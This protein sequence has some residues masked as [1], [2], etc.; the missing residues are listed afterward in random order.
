MQTVSSLLQR[1]P[2]ILPHCSIHHHSD[3]ADVVGRKATF[4]ELFPGSTADAI[5]LNDYL[6]ATG[7]KFHTVS[8]GKNWGLG[9]N[10]PPPDIN[11]VVNLSRLDQIVQFNREL[12][13][14]EIQPGV[15]QEKLSRFLA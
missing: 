10:F 4:V 1:L 13:Y 11:I 12:G 9:S 5:Q 2:E 14:V 7:S 3:V 6:R 8:T 15:T